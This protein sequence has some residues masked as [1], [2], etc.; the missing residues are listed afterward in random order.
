MYMK[1]YELQQ[2]FPKLIQEVTIAKCRFH[3]MQR[4][5]QVEMLNICTFVNRYNRRLHQTSS[6]WSISVDVHRMDAA[7]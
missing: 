6:C 3:G 1:R 2:F 4:N 7:D 5:K